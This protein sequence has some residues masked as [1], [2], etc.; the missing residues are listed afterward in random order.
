[1]SLVVGVVG[2]THP[3]S[4]MHLRTL[5]VADRVG[6]VVLCDS[7]PSVVT[8]TAAQSPKVV[9]TVGNVG[10]L[11]ARGDVSVV[12]ITLPNA[13]TPRTIVLAAD[14]GKHVLCEKPAARSSA[15]LRPAVEAVRRNNVKFLAF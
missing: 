15:E 8:T 7:D 9:G 10:D 6:G 11:F 13:T 2:L 3:H 4:A 5:D 14:A 12:L 1:M